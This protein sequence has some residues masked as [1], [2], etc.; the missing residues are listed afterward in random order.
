MWIRLIYLPLTK[1]G[2]FNV[3]S[4]SAGDMYL[5]NYYDNG[6]VVFMKGTE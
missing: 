6:N 2:P 4:P 3:V 5:C 1:F